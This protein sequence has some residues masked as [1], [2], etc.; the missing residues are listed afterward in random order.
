MKIVGLIICWFCTFLFLRLIILWSDSFHSFTVEQ[1]LLNAVF[2]CLSFIFLVII[3]IMAFR[4]K[5]KLF[6]L[7]KEEEKEGK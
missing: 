2:S 6:E 1:N 5:F 4:E 7:S 3:W